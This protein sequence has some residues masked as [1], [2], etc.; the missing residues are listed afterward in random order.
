MF[1]AKGNAKEM[2]LENIIKNDKWTVTEGTLGEHIMFLRYRHEISQSIDLTKFP[3]AIHI[4][5]D[6]ESNSAGMPS[7]HISDKMKLFED[8]LVDALENEIAGM[9]TAIITK[10][11]TRHWLYY[12]RD[13][14]TFSEKLHSMPQ[15]E[16]PYPIE[17]EAYTDP[18]WDYYFEGMYI[19]KST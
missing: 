3:K 2:S 11:G 6:F 10:E 9:L 17:I 14:N 1:C 8:R 12:V 15:E 19:P 13:T 4:F 7:G 16:E 5:W 18:S